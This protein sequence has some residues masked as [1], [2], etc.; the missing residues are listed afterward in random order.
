MSDRVTCSTGAKPRRGRVFQESERSDSRNRVDPRGLRSRPR[1]RREAAPVPKTL[2]P[3][4][5]HP[6][7]YPLHFPSP[8]E[9]CLAGFLPGL[10]V[11]EAGQLHWLLGL[12]NKL[13]QLIK[14]VPQRKAAKEQGK[15]P[16]VEPARST[17]KDSL[18][19]IHSA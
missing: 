17:E 6:T 4:T 3:Y 19:S 8:R 18:I 10:D 9:I 5:P 2:S 11:F 1:V 16:P 14:P 12:H 13:K 7:P 15:A